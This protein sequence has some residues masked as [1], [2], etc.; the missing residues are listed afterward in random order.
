MCVAAAWLA[1]TL[2]ARVA[3]RKK[4]PPC[5]TPKIERDHDNSVQETIKR[6]ISRLDEREPAD[7][8]VHEQDGVDGERAALVRQRLADKRHARKRRPGEADGEHERAHP[9]D[10]HEE[11]DDGGEVDWEEAVAD[12]AERLEEDDAAAEQDGVDGQ[13]DGAERDL[14]EHEL[15]AVEGGAGA[16]GN[17]GWG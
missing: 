14:G 7:R 11:A 4:T 10:V 8:D 6:P 5:R 16:R 17:E 3:A 15:S 13:H 12:E 1:R 9:R 2:Y